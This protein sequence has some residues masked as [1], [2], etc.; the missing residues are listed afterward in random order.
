MI[1][2]LMRY[3][4]TLKSV[5][6]DLDRFEK[7]V[8]PSTMSPVDR[9]VA[10]TTATRR[11]AIYAASYAYWRT[12]RINKLLEIFGVDYFKGKRILE[13]GS[14]LCDI[15][16]FFADLGAE[17]L[18][19]EGRAET[20]RFA[21]LRHRNVPRLRI[22]QFDLE[23]DFRSFGRFDM[24]L[25]F[26]LLYHLSTVDEHMARCFDIADEIML[27]TVVLDSLDPHRIVLLPGRK[28]VVEEALN[29]MG[30]RPSPFYIERLASE[31]GFEPI[32]HFTAD[33]NYEDKF[34]Y[35][36]KHK[37]N[38]DLG[39]WRAR[40]FWRLKRASVEDFALAS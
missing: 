13:V 22:E 3:L 10:L 27:E 16:A 37:D 33:L 36:W 4:R 39:G 34:V 21:Q 35:D 31:H 29:G 7:L 5:K 19:L 6:A 8:F 9:H 2:K 12:T 32:R 38:G 14:G 24:I 17:V 25:H 23:Q 15:G 28:D 40:R 1:G 11:D 18:C 26:G 30:S 20:V